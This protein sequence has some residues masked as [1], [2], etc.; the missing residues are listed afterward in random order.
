MDPHVVLEHC[1]S[2]RANKLV[3][4]RR[5][6]HPCPGHSITVVVNRKQSLCGREVTLY[7]GARREM[8]VVLSCN[9][10]PKRL[11]VANILNPRKPLT[12]FMGSG[13]P[14]GGRFR[15]CYRQARCTATLRRN[16]TTHRCWFSIAWGGLGSFPLRSDVLSP[17]VSYQ[18]SSRRVPPLH[19]CPAGTV[20]LA[21]RASQRDSM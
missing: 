14:W 1:P 12:A 4:M 6:N 17:A 13:K 21:S 8:S 2:W 19:L 7:A 20:S 18:K 3:R 16:G 9:P 11:H 10:D 5:T 15:H